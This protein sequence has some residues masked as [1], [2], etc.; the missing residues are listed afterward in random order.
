MFLLPAFFPY[1]SQ[2]IMM[3]P[4]EVEVR[5]LGDMTGFWR[6]VGWTDGTAKKM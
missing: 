2:Q 4:R 3:N 1:E 5:P 6:N